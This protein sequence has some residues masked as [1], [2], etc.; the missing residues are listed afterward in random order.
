MNSEYKFYGWINSH[1]FHPVIVIFNGKSYAF[2]VNTG[3]LFPSVYTPN[4]NWKECNFEKA[5]SRFSLEVQPNFIKSLESIGYKQ[6]QIKKIRI[7]KK[8]REEILNELIK[9]RATNGDAAYKFPDDKQDVLY[10]MVKKKL[11]GLV[12]GRHYLVDKEEIN[13]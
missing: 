8:V 10:F 3:N 11:I 13:H 5:L 1:A 7:T 4:F 2:P 9:N 6:E 12:N